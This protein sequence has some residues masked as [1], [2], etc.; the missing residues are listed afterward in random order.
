MWVSTERSYR[1]IQT[2]FKSAKNKLLVSHLLTF[3]VVTFMQYVGICIWLGDTFFTNESPTP[4]IESFRGGVGDVRNINT[5]SHRL[6]FTGSGVSPLNPLLYPLLHEKS[7]IYSKI[8]TKHKCSE[9]CEFSKTL[10]SIIHL[11]CLT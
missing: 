11:C 10:T 2:P 3:N 8:P 6:I 4:D 9:L 1:L 7:K 5:G